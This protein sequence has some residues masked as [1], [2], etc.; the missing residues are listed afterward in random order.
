MIRNLSY[1]IIRRERLKR[2]KARIMKEIFEQ[3]VVWM[4]DGFLSVI[5]KLNKKLGENFEKNLQSL[6][7]PQTLYSI[8][9]DIINDK[10]QSVLDFEDFLIKVFPDFVTILL[11]SFPS[12]F[13]LPIL[14]IFQSRQI[15]ANT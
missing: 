9:Q 8:E 12:L 13:L 10:Y 1:L 3:Q 14:F 4:R 2:E 15:N 5:R 11:F 7:E 6:P